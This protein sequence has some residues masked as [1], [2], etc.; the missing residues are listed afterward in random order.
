MRNEMIKYIIIAGG[1]FMMTGC[2]DKNA[3]SNAPEP[4]EV[5]KDASEAIETSTNYLD[6]QSKA[7]IEAAS[8]TYTDLESNIQ[9][10]ISEIKNSGKETTQ[11]MSKEL[12]SKLSTAKEK[13]KNLQEAGEENYQKAADVFNVAIEELK[14]TYEKTKDEFQKNNQK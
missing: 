8:K 12:D 7:A 10:L 2:K 6:A 9:G 11:D 13:L 5:I 3:D 14:D 1:I 4:N